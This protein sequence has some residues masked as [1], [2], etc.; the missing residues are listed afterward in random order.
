MYGRFNDLALEA[1]SLWVEV[2]PDSA[3]ARQSLVSV[4]V[5]NNKLSDAKPLSA[6]AAR[7]RQGDGR[8]LVPAI[9]SAAGPAR[10]Q[11]R[12][13]PAGPRS[14]G[15]PIRRCRKPTIRSRRRRWPP[16]SSMP[17]GQSAR[18]VLKLRPDWEPA[19]LLNAQVLQRESNAKAIDFLQGFLAANP[20]AR[21]A[22]LNY[23]RL[24]VAEKRIDPARREFQRIEQEAP[25]NADVA[26]TIGLLSLQ[27]NDFDTAEAK[28]KRALELNYR[29]PDA[30]RYYLGQVAEERKR[31]DEALGWYRQ[32][33]RRANR[34]FPRP[35]ATRSSSRGRTSWRRRATTCSSVEVQ[36]DA[37]AHAAHPGRGPGAARS[38]GLPGILRPARRRARQAARSSGSAVRLRAWPPRS[39][40]GSTCSRP[41]CAS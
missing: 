12:G 23:A 37:A 27:M 1:A 9:E 34:S 3:P 30:L 32:G 5:N 38:E 26:V 40:T 39:S 21:D 22:R 14:R 25:N 6:E 8:R 7:G 20:G 2:E 29:D 31:Y 4:L 41:S 11:E 18:Q 28:F 24:L 19:A 33:R 13:L 16:A 10:R 35:R 15:S 36:N 17:R